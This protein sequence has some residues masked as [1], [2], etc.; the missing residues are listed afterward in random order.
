MLGGADATRASL[1]GTRSLD[2]KEQVSSG[3]SVGGGSGPVG[4][5]A[6]LVR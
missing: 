2:Q 1:P 6:A 3:R 4:K 5:L